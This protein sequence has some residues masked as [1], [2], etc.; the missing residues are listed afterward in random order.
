[1]TARVDASAH[2]MDFRTADLCDQYPDELEISE[3]LFRDY[4][5]RRRFA[6]PIATIKC[7]EDNSRVRDLVAEAGHGRVLVIDAGG[8]TR[9][10]V[11]GD[12]LAQKAVDNGWAGVVI[13]G[14]L[15]DCAAIS[16][17]PLGVKA[18]GT[19]PLKTDKRGEGQRDLAVRFAGVRWQPGDWVYADEDGIV[20]A[21]R[22]LL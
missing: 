9:R 5:G 10:A 3:P 2:G 8:S 18:I 12:L 14:C 21:R 15:R 13:Y 20:V 1:M 4:G 7:F 6:G 19:C 22:S 16:A 17:M 11:L